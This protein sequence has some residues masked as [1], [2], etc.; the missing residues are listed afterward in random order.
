[1]KKRLAL[2][3]L[4]LVMCLSVAFAACDTTNNDKKAD[5]KA[6]ANYVKVLYRDK[7]VDVTKAFTRKT[8]VA[9]DNVSY[10]VAWSANVGDDKVKISAANN[11]EV[12]V[13]ADTTTT[14]TFEFTLTATVTKEGAEGSEKVEFKH[15]VTAKQSD[16]GKTYVPERV[17]LATIDTAKTYKLVQYNPTKQTNY[18]F[19]TEVF[20]TYYWS[21]ESDYKKAVDVTVAKTEKGYTLSVQ[22]DGATKYLACKVS[23]AHYNLVLQDAAYAFTY[24][25]EKQAL[26]CEDGTN[27]IGS[28]GKNQ[29]YGM[30]KIDSDTSF[31]AYIC[32]LKETVVAPKTAQEK[33]DEAAD[34]LTVA[35][36]T[37]N[38]DRV[39]PTTSA[40]HD[41]VTITWALE[42]NTLG[43]TLAADGKTLKI[44]SMPTTDSTI[45]L[46]ATLS[47]GTNGKAT[48]EI[49]VNVKAVSAIK[50]QYEASVITAPK[51]E[52]AYFLALYFAGND[53]VAEGIYYFTGAMEDGK[54]YSLDTSTDKTKAAKV[55]LETAGSAYRLYF[56]KD[57][58]KN[59]IELIAQ[60]N[61][62][63]SLQVK[64]KAT[65]S[66][67]WTFNNEYNILTGKYDGTNDG[68]LS[69]YTNSNG[70]L[71]TAIRGREMDNIE[72]RSYPARLLSAEITDEEAVA[73]TKESLTLNA[74]YGDTFTVPTTGEHGTAIAWALK[75]ANDKVTVNNGT[76]SFNI[77]E[78][79]NITLVAT[80]TK[81]SASATK[82]FAISLLKETPKFT[83]TWNDATITSVKNGEATVAS[84][85]QVDLNTTLTIT[86]APA[87][88]MKLASYKIGEGEAVTT[89]AGKTSF[90]I[91][92]TADTALS[93]QYV[94]QYPTKTIA[95]FKKADKNTE[96]KVTGI[97]TNMDSKAIFIQE[98]GGDALYLLDYG[99]H[100][101]GVA[102][103]KKVTYR[104]KLGEYNGLL[105][106]SKP[107]LVKVEDAAADEKIAA[108]VLDE[109]KYK[110]LVANDAAKLV[111]INDLVYQDGSIAVKTNINFKLGETKVAVRFEDKGESANIIA[112]LKNIKAGDKISLEN[113]NIGWYNGPQ[114]II[115]LVSSVKVAELPT[116]EKIAR[117]KAA[118]ESKTVNVTKAGEEVALPTYEGITITWTIPADATVIALSTDGLKIVAATLPAEETE[119]TVAGKFKIDN[120][121]GLAE[122]KV[123]VS[124]DGYVAPSVVAT[125]TFAPSS[126][127]SEHSD[128]SSTP[129]Y[130]AEV[131]GY[132]LNI[133]NGTGLCQKANDAKGN[134]ALKLGTKKA[135]GA[136]KITV[137]ATKVKSIKIYVAGYK[138]NACK[139]TVNGGETQ[140]TTSISDNGEY[141]CFEIVVP[142]DGIISFTTVNGGFRGMINKIEFL[143]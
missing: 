82:E 37:S 69:G 81:G 130:T 97:V 27:A 52:T 133:S 65:E 113:V 137:D 49:T 83:V 33:A 55:Y 29:S 46:T 123:K 103:G 126:N 41:D 35:D 127:T 125:F 58:V 71:Y 32:T 108:T 104:G 11:G 106:M 4:V 122:V 115:S 23:N 62:A 112:A 117:V 39:L 129:T 86:V 34:A 89:V 107:T 6:A 98:M 94:E 31:F 63:A 3:L 17:D 10:D 72:K 43:I 91:V 120:E 15:K 21:G 50:A 54:T 141:D 80:I 132:S 13:S 128:G 95:E 136:F 138:N 109:T 78:T 135:A 105:Q 51:A 76:V 19:T 26:V 57:G 45:K 64:T 59:Y 53:D 77:T 110:A 48:K 14:V 139:F 101:E 18:Y 66:A 25:T 12:T 28:F 116:A 143:G 7:D 70:K 118:L 75:E 96:Y 102:I 20:N 121:D 36:I 30:T 8:T 2:I 5:L 47:C 84:G 16:D 124:K 131:D 22:V 40:I 67:T 68:F 111:T 38:E 100:A 79:T 60:G 93:V 73:A 1:M 114:A 24:N 61:G 44:A 90:E 140:T 92:V 85:D 142:E 56:L 42:Q 74:S 119:V 9:V 87:E 134:G 88:G 99:K